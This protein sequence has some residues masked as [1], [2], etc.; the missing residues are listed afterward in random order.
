MISPL[1]D[2]AAKCG[3]TGKPGYATYLNTTYG[4]NLPAGTS[5]GDRTQVWQENDRSVGRLYVTKVGPGNLRYD[6]TRNQTEISVLGIDPNDRKTPYTVPDQCVQVPEN[7]IWRTD[8]TPN[9]ADPDPNSIVTGT[10]FLWSD[11]T[12]YI[13]FNA[14]NVSL[15]AGTRQTPNAQDKANISNM[16]DRFY[17]THRIYLY[18]D[19]KAIEDAKAA[20]K[21]SQQTYDQIKKIT[22]NL[23]KGISTGAAQK[24]IWAALPTG[25]P[26]GTAFEYPRITSDKGK[27][28]GTFQYPEQQNK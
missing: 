23:L 12:K 21:I 28:I 24:D 19:K 27:V 26:G 15:T 5:L 4:A 1:S 13:G 20:G 14:P 7:L 11:A 10:L 25:L 8:T 9:R 6:A 17:Q 18:V 2:T 3:I 16:R 22:Q